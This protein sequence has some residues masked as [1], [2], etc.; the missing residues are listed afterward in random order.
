MRKGLIFVLALGL[1]VTACSKRKLLSKKIV[2]NP[3]SVPQTETKQIDPA[4]VRSI[5]PGLIMT[6][7]FESA[8]Q[9]KG[10]YTPDNC[11]Q[12]V[13]LTKG[14]QVIGTYLEISAVICSPDTLVAENDVLL[15]LKMEQNA[16]F[17]AQYRLIVEQ[18]YS[19]AIG[20]IRK[21]ENNGTT[22]Y[23][24]DGLCEIDAGG[25]GESWD[26]FCQ[27]AIEGS[28]WRKPDP[29]DLYNLD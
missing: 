14:T 12:L 15:R 17:A 16:Q 24:L 19:P 5:V 1:L 23:R 2:K 10:L 6:P 18:S 28:F 22:E 7:E 29:L 11:F 3:P 25:Y 27:L 9:D 21:I 4:V 26:T 8:I 20:A 13:K